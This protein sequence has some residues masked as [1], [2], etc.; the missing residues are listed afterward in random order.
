MTVP[1]ILLLGKD[2]QIGSAL[3]SRLAGRGQVFAHNRATCD[4]ANADQM[5]DVIRGA[6]PNV[7]VSA[8]AYTAVD[9]AEEDEETCFRINAAA[10]AIIAEEAEALG[11]WL[12]HYSTD[13]VF[14]GT[15][16]TAYLED[17]APS[18]L[19]VY[20]RSKIAGDQA[21][22]AATENYTIL[23]V[24][25]VYD[26]AGRNFA[27]TILR[28]AAERDELRIVDD[29]VGA[30]TSAGLIADVTA[31]IFDCRGAD[32]TSQDAKSAR[33]VFNLAPVG[34]VSWHGYALELI[35]EAKRQ[36]RSLRVAEEQVIP[37]T[38]EQHPTAA[39]RPRNSMLD[40]RR[41]RQTFSLDLPGWQ[42]H[43]RH[44][45]ANWRLQ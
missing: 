17:D 32:V 40:T 41:I 25:W 12:I 31:R 10:P 26:L 13:Y 24:S 38:S 29:Q 36:G 8:A 9:K 34:C 14:D 27:K 39:T 7:I 23:R 43:L 44:F 18:P 42:V 3:Q 22:A 15:K 11:A 4:L 37:I 6:Q 16:E 20:G 5:R 2:G 33:G 1:R 45:V 35:R 21:I 28:L 30:P 19:S